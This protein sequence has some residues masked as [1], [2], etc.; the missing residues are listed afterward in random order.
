MQRL[1]RY[2]IEQELGRGAMGTVYRARDPKIGRSVALKTITVLRAAPAEAA[3]YRARFFREAQAAGKLS[4]PGIVTIYDVGED[5]ATQ[6]PYMVM[7]F[8]EG[9][10][11]ERLVASAGSELIPLETSLELI[12][13]V[14]QALDYAHSQNIVHRD[15]KP[16]NILVTPE[17]RA[18]I[19]DFGVAKLP[20]TQLTLAGQVLGTPAYMSPEQ[21]SGGVVDGRSDLFALGSILYWLLTGQKPFAADTATAVLFKVVYKDPPPPSQL[22][23]NL[24]PEFDYVLARALAKDPKRRYQ[25]G[26]ELADDLD[27][28]RYGCPPRSL[29]TAVLPVLPAEATVLSKPGQ[30]P[31]L[32][33]Q[34]HELSPEAPLPPESYLPLGRWIP[35]AVAVLVG[36]MLIAIGFG[37]WWLREQAS[38]AAEQPLGVEAAGVETPTEPLMPPK[39]TVAPRVSVPAAPPRRPARPQVTP[40]ETATLKLVSDH[41]FGHA[42]I[43]IWL[44]GRLEYTG[45]LTGEQRW[46]GLAKM[47][48]GSF[49]ASLPVP[50]GWHN[51]KVRVTSSEGRGFDQTEEIQGEFGARMSRTLELH[52]GKLGALGAR[53]LSLRWKN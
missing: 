14:A 30:S 8:I 5:E 21:V 51:I 3:A 15:I 6:T 33:P 48:R 1:G 10:T 25:R 13:Q 49:R 45:A 9:R 35:A 22:N 23:P 27:D 26:R 42:R 24:R 36:T 43:Y 28:L 29:A 53:N 19:A 50:P 37:V 38:S 52:F 16:A 17:G 34:P 32:P 7:E 31:V 12:Q 2:E 41:N 40:A 18:K 39:Q 11:L 46:L 44:E 47:T 4:H 20:T